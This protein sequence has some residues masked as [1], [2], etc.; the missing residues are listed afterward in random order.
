MRELK[1]DGRLSDEC[2]YCDHQPSRIL[3]SET[4]FAGKLNYLFLLLID[5][6]NI[7]NLISAYTYDL[8]IR[9]MCALFSLICQKEDTE[10]C[11][12][13]LILFRDEYENM[14]A[15]KLSPK[16][17][18]SDNAAAIKNSVEMVLPM[19]PNYL[20]CQQHFQ[21]SVAKKEKMKAL[22]S[23][24]DKEMFKRFMNELMTIESTHQFEDIA[25]EFNAWIHKDTAR[26]DLL[27]NWWKWW[28]DRR[29]TWPN[30]Y[31]EPRAA[32]TNEAEKGNSRYREKTNTTMLDLT[33]AVEVMCVEYLQHIFFYESL[34]A[35]T[36]IPSASK[37][38]RSETDKKLSAQEERRA[39]NTPVS[40]RHEQVMVQQSLRR[41]LRE[42]SDD[43]SLL[44][45][46][47]DFMEA[48]EEKRNQRHLYPKK[49]THKPDE[50]NAIKYEGVSFFSI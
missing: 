11:A 46:D 32:R 31:R 27:S 12:F 23:N 18:C 20:T 42:S 35:G 16:N 17:V 41:I 15:E 33:K 29:F 22:G 10:S 6:L 40:K 1:A 9:R 49:G 4:C 34:I 36:Y 8:D 24:K 39:Q 3:T 26:A 28:F 50:G 19:V 45:M 2:L 13:A 44:E 47:E 14:F 21:S 48:E 30:A 7:F 5:L 38:G 37:R 25:K 43:E